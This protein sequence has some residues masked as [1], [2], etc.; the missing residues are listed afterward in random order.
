MRREW[1]HTDKSIWGFGAWLFEPDKV[2]WIDVAT[3]LDCLAVRNRFGVW[4]GYVGLPP[5][6][7]LHGAGYDEVEEDAS[8]CGLTFAGPCAEGPTTHANEGHGIC[9]VPA[10]GRPANVWWLG[11]DCNHAGDCSP[12]HNALFRHRFPMDE[13]YRDLAYVQA[14]CRKLAGE[15]AGQ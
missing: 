15:L 6:H 7:K 4:C 3:G 1:T 12:Q 2:Q 14:C 9:H 5:G 11:F 13:V 8:H 10:P